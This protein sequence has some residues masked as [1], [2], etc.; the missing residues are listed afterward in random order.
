MHF[1]VFTNYYCW[2][3][4]FDHALP[5]IWFI[6]QDPVYLQCLDIFI[7]LLCYLTLGA[8]FIQVNDYW[9]VQFSYQCAFPI[10]C[11]PGFL[12][13]IL[14]TCSFCVRNKLCEVVNVILSFF[15]PRKKTHFHYLR[16]KIE[17]SVLWY[18]LFIL[19]RK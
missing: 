6:G 4:P 10:Q 11:F 1:L 5:R 2:N 15:F 18:D 7:F 8:I 14:S 17:S 9:R 12:C 13:N 3:Y 19:Q 16:S